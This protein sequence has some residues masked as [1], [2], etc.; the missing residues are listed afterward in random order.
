MKNVSAIKEKTRTEIIKEQIKSAQNNQ[1]MLNKSY[2]QLEEQQ[3]NIQITFH[4]LQ[5]CI[6]MLS[7]ELQG[8]EKEEQ[9]GKQLGNKPDN[10]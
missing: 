10:S 2:I 6:E 5:G 4:K 8:L 3:K 9:N 1:E 7:S